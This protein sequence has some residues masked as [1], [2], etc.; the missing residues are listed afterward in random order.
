MDMAG[1]REEERLGGMEGV[2]RKHTLPHV[3]HRAN[4]HL[5]H[6]SEN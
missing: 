2:I 4:G 6:D 5:L 1:G 3:K